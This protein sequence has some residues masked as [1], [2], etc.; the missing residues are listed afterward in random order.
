MKH[1]KHA[2]RL[3]KSFGWES[4]ETRSY[5]AAHIVGS[6]TVYSTIQ[7]AVDAAAPGATINVDAGTYAETV[8]IYKTLT[9]RGANA[10]TD[11]RGARKAESIIYN[12]P[13]DIKIYANDVTIDGFVIQGYKSAIGAGMGA[14]IIM[15]PSIHG[16]H[17][18]NNIIQ[19]NVTGLYLSNNSD[20]DAAVIQH[21]YFYNNY[22]TNS[23]WTYG[24]N[25]SRQIYTDGE[26]SG[27]LLTNVLI[28]GN[29]FKK[30]ANSTGEGMI[31]LAA[32][33]P[34]KQFN[35]TISN[36]TFTSNYTSSKAI[37]VFNSTNLSFVGNDVSGQNDSSSGPVRFEGGANNVV[38]AYNNIHDNYGPAV[39]VD[40][41]G[42]PYDSSGFTIQYNNFTNNG[43][44]ANNIGVITNSSE[45]YNGPTYA[46]NNWWGAST[47]PSGLGTGKG[48]AVWGNGNTGHYT[49]PTGKTG[50][51]VYFSPWATA[52]IDTT[53]IPVPAAAA[54]LTAVGTSTTSI[55]LS[56][57]AAYSTAT[58]QVIQRS[59]D[60]VNFTTLATVSPLVNTFT[61]TGVT[62][63]QKFY[64]RVVAANATGNATPSNIA[65]SGP[66]VYQPPVAPTGLSVS[67][68]TSNTVTLVWTP[69]SNLFGVTGY[70]VYRNGVAI[71]TSTS[72]TFT[73]VGLPSSSTYSYAVAT[74]D[75]TGATSS[76]SPAVNATTQAAQFGDPSFEASNISTYAYSP[77]NPYWVFNAQ[78]GI[79]ANGSAWGAVNAPNGTQAAF[80]QGTGTISQTLNIGVTGSYN[81][82]FSAARRANFGIDPIAFSVDGKVVGTITPGS[83]NFT[84]YT[85][86][87]F[88]L[89]AGNHTFSFAGTNGTGDNDSFID[90][91][92]LKFVAS[93]LPP[94]APT[95]LAATTA[96]KSQINLSWLTTGITPSSFTLLRS[97]DNVNFTPVTTAIAG[98]ATSYAD[99]TGLTAGTTYYYQLIAVNANGAS[100]ASNTASGKTL[101]AA[102][103]VTPLSSLTWTSATAGWKTPQNNASVAG[104]TIT[105]KGKTYASGVGTHAAST[106]TYNLG[107]AYT[108]FQSDIGIDDE[109]ASTKT[110]AV[111]F[112]VFGDG[113]LLFDS[114][115]LNRTSP[116]MSVNVSV[117]GVQTLKLVATNGIAND[118]DNDH[119]DW[120][121]AQL[122][123]NPTAPAAPTSVAANG[124]STSSIQVTWAATGTD[125]SG[126]TIDRST[127]GTNWTPAGTVA[128]STLSF[129]DTGL[130]AN[131]S[132]SYRVRATNSAGDSPNSAVATG[133]TL[134]ATATA[135]SLSSIAWT[136]AT[137]G[138]GTTQ[139]NASI[140]G[141]TLTLR[142]QTYATG[143]GTH[144]SSTITYN[145]AGKYTNFL[146]DIG[147]DDEVNGVGTGTVIFQV[148]GD[149]KVLYDSGAV[150]NASPIQSLNVNVAGVQTLTLIAT[151]PDGNIDFAHADWAGATLLS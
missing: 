62:N 43:T 112:Q 64:Y 44:R 77:A 30:D 79:E 125:L 95:N 101:A 59:T 1:P 149:G 74:N 127:D 3:K 91:V 40:N 13:T 21:N 72:P 108:L 14:G 23:D 122:L 51:T 58:S 41:A 135:T 98:T 139:L 115:V 140:K 29:L 35:I 39:A 85:T 80:I 49:T 111:D 16:T 97:T 124:L 120:A 28:D 7:A 70:T 94:A 34:G 136:S 123:A 121:G 25:G 11:A 68:T 54:N 33:G 61:D 119:A 114:G 99:T 117:A 81:V 84:S 2:A 10:G 93:T 57:T 118:I 42:T 66:A 150:T 65:G 47:G 141:N 109:V 96:S 87:N 107:G 142:G 116:T 12:Q 26:V 69:P 19:N 6:N 9:L 88:N 132:Y 15:E 76:K 17:V 103:T 67:G 138:W 73:D 102:A 31:A 100:G 151:T 37:I 130:A 144:A 36:N 89:T 63:S 131:T 24:W 126:F 71:G 75:N 146:S 78:S 128:A 92:S 5:L 18:V 147:V 38:I 145:L 83:N 143:I 82:S 22:E 53:K 32:Q 8:S 113:V 133:K 106:I 148:I 56:W 104:N 90:S 52:K 46:Q 20:T 4:M 45:G 110:A 60:G 129:T 105:L 27:G 134:S 55:A 48:E 86:S 137:A 50:G